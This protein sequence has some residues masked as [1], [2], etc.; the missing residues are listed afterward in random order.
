MKIVVIGGTGFIGAKL[1]AKLR[2]EG[3]QVVA[4]SPRTGV[5]AFTGAGLADAL[6]DAHVVVDVVNSPSFEDAAALE[7]FQRSGRNL[8]AAEATAGVR[9]HVTLSIVGIDRGSGSGY[10]KAKLAQE[11]SVK[12]SSLPYTI[13]RSTQFFEFIGGIAEA[14]VVDGTI[15]ISPALVAPIAADDV[16]TALAACSTEPPLNDT[17]EIAG[18]DAMP[19]DEMVRRWLSAH[20]DRRPVISDAHAKYFGLELDDRSLTPAGRPRLGP[21]HFEAWLTGAH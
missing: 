17:I 11:E 2:A 3:A 5:D 7:F 19:L 1:V 21:T 15:H 9:H 14:G 18:P 12:T 8:V 6:V 10:F 4:A 20:D 13:V 16:V